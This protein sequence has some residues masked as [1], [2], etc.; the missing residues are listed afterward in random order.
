M[1]NVTVTS[2]TSNVNVNSTTNEVNVT[3]TTSNVIVGT[4]A[5]ADASSIRLSISANDTGGDGSLSYSNVSGVI[6]YTGPSASEV[7]A[8]LSNTSPILYDASTGVISLDSSSVLQSTFVDLGNKSGNVAIDS[9]LGDNFRL[10]LTGNLTGLDFS[11]VNNGDSFTILLVQDSIGGHQIDTTTHSSFWSNFEFANGFKTLDTNPNHWNILSIVYDGSTPNVFYGSL[12]VEEALGIT[13]SDLANSSITLNDQVINLGDTTTL[14]KLTDIGVNNNDVN[15]A[16]LGFRTGNLNSATDVGLIQGTGNIHIQ[17]GGTSNDSIRFI[18]KTTFT[19]VLNLS[20]GAVLETTNN[21]N[22]TGTSPGDKVLRLVDAN[23]DM[24]HAGANIEGLTSNSVVEGTN[25]YFTNARANSA[26]GAYQG[27]ISTAG[28]ITAGAGPLSTHNFTGNVDIAGNITATGNI[29]YQNVTDLYVRDQSITLNANAATD[30]TVSI[31]ANRPQAGANTVLRWNETDDKWQFSNDGTAYE[32][33]SGLTNAQA[34]AFIQ[35]SGLTMTSN[36]VSGSFTIDSTLDGRLHYVRDVADSDG[37][38]ILKSEAYTTRTESNEFNFYKGGGSAASPSTIGNNDTVHHSGYWAHDGT[39]FSSLPNAGYWVFYDKDTDSGIGANNVPL[40][41]EFYVNPTAG[42]GSFQS[43]VLKLTPDRR[44]VF[45]NT[46]TRGF[47]NNRGLASIEANGSIH[48]TEGLSANNTISTTVGSISGPT[49]TDTVLSINSGAINSATTGTFSGQVSAGTLTDGVLQITGGNIQLI[50]DVDATGHFH[51]QEDIKSFGSDIISQL[52]NVEAAAGNIVGQYL[53]G[54]GSNVTLVGSSQSVKRTVIAGTNLSKGEVVY[55][56]GGTGD[57]PEVSKADASDPAKMPAFGVTTEAIGA[58]LTTDLLVYGE[59]TS[60]DTTAFTTGD[61]LFVDAATPGALTNVAPT[62][63]T[64]LIQ[65]IGK[66]IK[67]GSSGGKI[68]VTGA[69]R[70][71]ATPN[72]DNNKIFIGNAANRA[73]TVDFSTQTNTAIGAYTGTMTNVGQITSSGTVTAS[74]FSG[75]ASNLTASTIP[76]NK[77]NT[78]AQAYIISQGLVNVAGNITS[79]AN[80]TTNTHLITNNLT[81][82]SDGFTAYGTKGININLSNT[83]AA[84]HINQPML[85]NANSH[86]LDISSKGWAP[87]IYNNLNPVSGGDGAQQNDGAGG[88]SANAQP[89]HGFVANAT[90]TAGSTTVPITGITRLSA[91]YAGGQ[92]VSTMFNDTANIT[93]IMGEMQANSI[94]KTGSI[95]AMTQAPFAK[96][97]YITAIDA[98]ARTITVSEAPIA[99]ATLALIDS[100]GDSSNATLANQ[101]PLWMG[102]GAFAVPTGG[103]GSQLKYA[104]LYVSYAD[105]VGNVADANYYPI[106]SITCTLDQFGAPQ[107]GLATTDLTYTTQNPGSWTAADYTVSGKTTLDVEDGAISAPYGLTI[108]NT[109]GMGYKTYNDLS[110]ST[111]GLNVG[112]DGEENKA[113]Y[114]GAGV[115]IPQIGMASFTENTVQ[116]SILSNGPRLIFQSRNGNVNISEFDQYPRSGQELGRTTFWG[117]HGNNIN[118]STT[119]APGYISFAAADDWTDGSNTNAYFVATSNYTDTSSRDPFLTYEKGELIIASGQPTSVQADI[120]FAPAVSVGND[121]QNAYD[122]SSDAAAAGSK[123]W[124]SINYANVTATSGSKFSVNNGKSLGAGTVGDMQVSIHRKDNSYALANTDVVIDEF[125]TGATNSAAT[126]GAQVCDLVGVSGGVTLG[127]EDRYTFSGITDANWTFLNG[128][129]YTFASSLFGGGFK[130]LKN[131]DGS[132][133]VQGGAD[134]GVAQPSIGQPF[135]VGVVYRIVSVGTT[136]FT[137]I[138][139]ADNNIGTTFTASGTGSGSGIGSRLLVGQYTFSNSQSSGVTDRD[140]QFSIAEQSE[141]FKL[142]TAGGTSSTHTDLLEV[143]SNNGNSYVGGHD[144]VSHA[145]LSGQFSG[146]YNITGT[147][148]INPALGNFQNYSTATGQVAGT[149]TLDFDQF[150]QT[151]APSQ[152]NRTSGGAVYIVKMENKTGNAQT[153]ATTNTTPTHSDSLAN[154]SSFVYRITQIGTDVIAEKIK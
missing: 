96:G 50:H 2:S 35:S 1:A 15:A 148:Q 61:S 3:S 87:F 43:S 5:I 70:S 60:Y 153:I 21:I 51:A 62:G 77:T 131:V 123:G 27:N 9:S 45:Q 54:D 36:I 33:I 108:G 149:I 136:D 145:T 19:D 39:Q 25:L 57:N 107:T 56:S 119:A 151:S 101:N 120:R 95:F 99:N 150:N 130:Q 48:T 31:I 65:K 134:R 12:V 58:T 47:G 124:A 63:E 59:H 11:N 66:V 69:G 20:S 41:H 30:A 146:T 22:I 74:L 105:R 103:S 37:E 114:G 109:T 29:N 68:T 40:A 4:T 49:L 14:A 116:Q 76:T 67:G 113:R 6:T 44:V 32:N 13:N 64:N 139:A 85:S 127:S 104:E 125:Y 154:G 132:N 38:I 86:V 89:L 78:D 102:P 93:T 140:Y 143:Y 81:G 28:T 90:L 118:P 23:I 138:G 18:G 71:N 128:N 52:G 100:P 142:T 117:T 137:A 121:P 55:I 34:Q 84:V 88:P 122:F 91:Y 75:D 115:P 98:A 112:W 126:G 106:Y 53:H 97:T 111:F 92:K 46:G 110:G 147:N 7:R 94:P 144:I 16:F 26:I 8:H 79:T 129:T 80:I 73:T 10:D 133:V 24:T 83:V 42:S 141:N 82:Y 72:L 135:V 17:S 152:L